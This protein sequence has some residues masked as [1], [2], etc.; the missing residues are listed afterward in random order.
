MPFDL[1]AVALGQP[2]SAR[3]GGKDSDARRIDLAGAVLL[4]SV[5]QFSDANANGFAAAQLV[6]G[7]C[8]VLPFR[9][10]Q[11]VGL[12]PRCSQQT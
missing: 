6:F 8:A 5:Q 10:P 4:V 12:L 7:I 3:P 2:G 11:F 9:T 1:K